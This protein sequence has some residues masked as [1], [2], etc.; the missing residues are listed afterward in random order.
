MSFY[1]KPEF[2]IFTIARVVASGL[3]VWALA[4]HQIGYFTILRLIVCVVCA[5]G[6][7]L[8]VQWKQQGWIFPF[9]ALVLLFQPLVTLRI[10][11]PTWNYIDVA[12]AAF[13]ILTIPFFRKS[14]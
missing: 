3:L 12:V 1:K 9:A 14:A 7:W 6:V 5:A 8:A 11:R 2:I 13:L 10:T 4:K